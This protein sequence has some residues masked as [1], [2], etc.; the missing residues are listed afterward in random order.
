MNTALQAAKDNL[1]EAGKIA[2]AN[3]AIAD[4]I[5]AAEEAKVDPAKDNITAA[6]E[7]INAAEEAIAKVT[8]ADKQAE[9]TADLKEAQDNL[10]EAEDVLAAIGGLSAV[11]TQAEKAITLLDEESSL[12]IIDSLVEAYELLNNEDT[13]LDQ[14]QTCTQSLDSVVREALITYL[15][16]VDDLSS[17]YDPAMFTT[18]TW[19]EL[20]NLLSE[21]NEITDLFSKTTDQ[22]LDLVT[23]TI[24]AFG[25]LELDSS[26]VQPIDIDR[27]QVDFSDQNTQIK[28]QI[29]PKTDEQG[30]VIPDSEN[31]ANGSTIYVLDNL[32][33]EIVRGTIVDGEVTFEGLS[34]LKDNSQLNYYLVST[35]GINSLTAQITVPD[36]TPPKDLTNQD[37]IFLSYDHI[38]GS[39]D[40][41]EAGGKVYIY[42]SK[43]GETVKLDEATIKQ[44]GGFEFKLDTP[45][46]PQETISFVVF[47]KAG[48]SSINSLEVNTPEFAA[49]IE[50]NSD[51][52]STN[53]LEP[54]DIEL[55]KVKTTSGSLVTVGVGGL[56][57]LGIIDISKQFVLNLPGTSLTE[58]DD[59]AVKLSS[60]AVL[61]LELGSTGYVY[62]R[63]NES[64]DW[65]LVDQEVLSLVSLLGIPLVTD[66]LTIKDPKAGQYMVLVGS[67]GL[68]AN[69]AGAM[70]IETKGVITGTDDSTQLIKGNVLKNDSLTAG[71]AIEAVEVNT[72]DLPQ[73]VDLDTD[74][75]TKITGKYGVLTIDQSGS[76]TY[77]MFENNIQNVGKVDSF[78]YYVNGE[79][80]QLN[81][82]I[83]SDKY[84]NILWDQNNPSS[85]GVILD[86]NSDIAIANQ[87]SI[88][89][90]DQVEQTASDTK[91][92][93]PTDNAYL[94]NSI[95]LNQ[96]EVLQIELM[97]LEGI[98]YARKV[99]VQLKDLT[100]EIL[101]LSN[102]KVVIYTI[103]VNGK[104][105][106]YYLSYS[107]FNSEI[108][109]T[110]PKYRNISANREKVVIEIQDLN[111][112]KNTT[113]TVNT[114]ASEGDNTTTKYSLKQIVNTY[115]EIYKVDT[116]IAHH[117]SGNIFDNDVVNFETTELFVFDYVQQTFVKI[118]ANE[119]VEIKGEYGDLLINKSGS[120]TY[121]LRNSTDKGKSDAF[122]YKVTDSL[123]D[124]LIKVSELTIVNAGNTVLSSKASESF[125]FTSN[126]IDSLIYKVLDDADSLG[127]NGK[128]AVSGFELPSETFNGDVIDVS[129]LL[130]DSAT[131]DNIGQYL[132]YNADTKTVSIDR[133]GEA[134][135]YESTELLKV[136]LGTSSDP[137]KDLLESGNIII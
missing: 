30:T 33:N 5:D 94:S 72:G 117:S 42:S 14:L 80:A 130:A 36:I 115:K 2:T 123:N 27:V 81:I 84:P 120:F 66:S 103:D 98:T 101:D 32:G 63:A 59:I 48:N 35:S 29:K 52:V 135:Y 54:T 79:S 51:V 74:V 97:K 49:E 26:I 90:N 16:G 4:A 17:S 23:Q 128:D 131:V 69:V 37:V 43:E 19:N 111:I 108:E 106:P 78:T 11:I 45:L 22:L 85:D 126:K 44:D 58:Y 18:D 119:V 102:A 133:D 100:G 70:T 110:V 132:S 93:S 92:I 76:Y 116:E 107:T 7:A 65:Q 61:N 41:E 113:L 25:K 50:L 9:L 12:V 77:Q 124:T 114:F 99:K 13:T 82:Q 68:K 21:I 134:K 89:K 127:G 129:G 104:N 56:I 38:I 109:V 6:E 20:S 121:T 8:D 88:V 86:L 60:Y 87:I 122:E 105:S 95:T 3:S 55:S 91:D 71:V 96:N 47:D 31:D 118:E 34:K 28:I 53:I 67:P 137:I 75:S 46:Q 15:E 136:D 73:K 57:D 40:S 125:E 83:N 1:V 10:V 62:Y 64:Q 39:T 112:A 24:E